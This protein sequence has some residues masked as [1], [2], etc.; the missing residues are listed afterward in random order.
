MSK[1]LGVVTAL[2]GLATAWVTYRASVK[3]SI[4]SAEQR[5]PVLAITDASVSI[6]YWNPRRLLWIQ[7]AI[8][9]VYLVILWLLGFRLPYVLVMA[10]LGIVIGMLG[11]LFLRHKPPSRVMKSASIVI[12]EQ[13]SEAVR[14]CLGVLQN[15]GA[16]IARVDQELGL[17]QARMPMSFW[18]WG[19][20]V[21]ITVASDKS[22]R[23]EIR[24]SSDS[25]MPSALLDFGVNARLVRRVISQLLGP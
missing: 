20:I 16:R 9:A 23:S 18:S 13:R 10:G 21:N 5:A 1:Y 12:A 3:R 4:T 11:T 25:I 7:G 8:G 19:N 24:V 14:R 15:I 2:I 22:D 17:I 6:K